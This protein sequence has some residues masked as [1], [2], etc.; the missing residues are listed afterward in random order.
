MTSMDMQ[1]FRSFVQLVHLN[2][3]ITLFYKKVPV[4]R[5][6]HSMII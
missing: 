4:L 1:F 5:L 6:K 2:K 3:N